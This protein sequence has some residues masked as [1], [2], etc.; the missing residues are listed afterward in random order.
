MPIEEVALWESSRIED[1]TPKAPLA[2]GVRIAVHPAPGVTR[3]ALEH[4]LRCGLGTLGS[5]LRREH[6]TEVH[7]TEDGLRYL[8][9]ARFASRRDAERVVEDVKNESRPIPSTGV[10]MQH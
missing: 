2:D 9:W 5:R 8:V 10:R 1:R 4:A 6:A 7:V 3:A